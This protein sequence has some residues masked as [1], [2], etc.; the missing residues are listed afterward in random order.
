MFLPLKVGTRCARVPKFCPHRIRYHR[1]FPFITQSSHPFVAP[2][3]LCAEMTTNSRPNYWTAK[4]RAMVFILAASS[5]ACLLLEFYQVCPMRAF[6][7]FAFL[8]AV[9][10]LFV[11]AFI[12][13]AKGD[14]QLWRNVMIG[15]IAGLA[16]AVA[17]DVFRLPFVFAKAWGIASIVPQMNLFKVFPRFGAM[18]LGQPLEQSAYSLGAQLIGWT[19]HFSNGL[20]FG[21]MYVAMIGDARK[22]KWVWGIVMAVGLELGM[23][24][25]PYPAVFAIPVTALFVAVTLTAH[26]IFGAVMGKSVQHLTFRTAVA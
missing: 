14:R 13:R 5:I 19:Y 1:F 18:I 12:D 15:S 7:L 25:T 11:L 10:L 9:V 26:L 24:L 2:V 6:T 16:A 20:T 3:T 23:L 8:P 17:Y 4:G 21:V 22:A